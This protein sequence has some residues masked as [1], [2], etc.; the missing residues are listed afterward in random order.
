VSRQLSGALG[1]H[2]SAQPALKRWADLLVPIGDDDMQYQWRRVRSAGTMH[3]RLIG[4]A[5]TLSAWTPPGL[6]DCAVSA[7]PA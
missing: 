4:S 5:H 1:S 2:N 7:R 3:S 6:N